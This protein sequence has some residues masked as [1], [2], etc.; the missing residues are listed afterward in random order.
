MRMHCDPDSVLAWVVH[1]THNVRALTC[2]LQGSL[3]AEVL[4][5]QYPAPE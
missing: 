5:V 3:C 1:S 2:V 4:V